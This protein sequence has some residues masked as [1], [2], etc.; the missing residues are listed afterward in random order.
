LPQLFQSLLRVE[1][2]DSELLDRPLGAAAP[3]GFHDAGSRYL[4]CRILGELQHRDDLTPLALQ[5]LA[6][7]LVAGLGR[8][9]RNRRSRGPGWLKAIDELLEGSFHEPLSL[10][11]M[12]AVA[13][14]HAVHLARTYRQYRRQ[15]LGDR[16]RDL[17]LQRACQLL[18]GTR[19]SIAGI[20]SDCGFA[21]QSHLARL[22]RRKLG[23]SP[24]EYRA[25]RNGR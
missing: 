21:D 20:A 24:S 22:M 2:V 9:A 23:V 25:T 13:G 4:C 11:R 5:G 18:S 19:G 1:A 8:S 10:A 16:I 15:T 6:Y 17:R 12:A 7:E 3:E 14:V